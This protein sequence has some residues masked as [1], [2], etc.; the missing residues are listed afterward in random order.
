MLWYTLKLLLLLPL[1]AGLVWGSLWL[2]RKMQARMVAPGGEKA[3]RLV[4]TTFL[5]PGI[6]LA[7]IEF[8]GREILVG[9]TKQGLVR[10]AE[11]DPYAARRQVLPADTREWEMS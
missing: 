2:T 7:V 6:R 10:L 9:A 5:A 3:A 11:N 8:R 1:L 4:E